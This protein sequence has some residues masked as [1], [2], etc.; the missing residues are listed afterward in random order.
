MN[1]CKIQLYDCICHNIFNI[2]NRLIIIHELLYWNVI[3]SY[4]CLKS[5]MNK[6]TNYTT[7]TV[8]FADSA[9]TQRLILRHRG[10]TPHLPSRQSPSHAMLALLIYPIK[11]RIAR[12]SIRSTSHHAAFLS[13]HEYLIRCVPDFIFT[14]RSEKT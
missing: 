10:Q 3:L 2:L 5:A 6:I 12:C 1:E 13:D 8:D 11:R 9:M 7:L 14:P 4:S